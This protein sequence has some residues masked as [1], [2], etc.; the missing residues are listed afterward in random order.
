MEKPRSSIKKN[1]VMNAI[2]SISGFLFPLISFP[3]ASRVLGPSGTGKVDF[4][5]SFVSYFSLIASLGIPF[6]GI[7]VCAQ[8]RDDRRK[9][10]QT[11]R[12]LMV[13]HAVMSTI[14]ILIFVPFLLFLPRVS[15]DKPLFLVASTTL[16]FNVIGIEYL[17]KG[18][19]QYSYITVRS[20]IFKVISIMSLFVFVKSKSDY[21]MYGAVSVFAASASNLINLINAKNY[22][23]FTHL[24]KCN[25]KRHFKPI[26]VFFAMSCAVSLYVSL[27]RVMLGFIT[28]DSEV[29]FY[30]AAAKIKNILV[31]FITS[32]GNVLMP[33][34]AYCVE[35]NQLEEF[36]RLTEKALKFVFFSSIP[37]MFFSIIF[38]EEMTLFVSG[39]E[40]LPAVLGLQVIMPTIV[41]IGLT[42]LI[43]IQI[44]VPLGKE[45]YVLYSEIAGAVTDLVLNALL[46]PKYRATGAAIGTL[47]AEL[48]VLVVQLYLLK[49]VRDK[50]PLLYSFRKIQYWKIILGCIFAVL[51]SLTTKLI[52]FSSIDH[53]GF[54]KNE[55]IIQMINIGI[56]LVP[57]GI[58]FFLLY[59]LV[60]VLLKEDTAIEII[61]TAKKKLKL[62]S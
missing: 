36:Q 49:Y 19:E 35:H 26:A 53:V 32:L 55:K 54:I 9:L 23:S 2:L 8:V 61:K 33:R 24:G 25:Y 44:F 37:C 48:V 45:K 14:A 27:D 56:R 7:R 22:I 51:C 13:I 40:Y 30:G 16:F 43:G 62:G 41:F 1:F 52:S 21:V 18:L 11:V 5:L 17:Y 50:N 38:A 29:G 15:S 42:G 20:L 31:A 60:L 58:I 28:N 3:Y 34:A 12:E 57:A 47:I 6:Y 39:E 10:S 46:I 59:L 4:A